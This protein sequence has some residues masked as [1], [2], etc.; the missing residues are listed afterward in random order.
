MGLGYGYG[1]GA[2]RWASSAAAL[3][4]REEEDVEES[5]VVASG[6]RDMN[7]SKLGAHAVERIEVERGERRS[8]AIA[9]GG[10]EHGK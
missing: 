1:Y 8:L 2:R 6:S 7:V 4:V 10:N 9:E 3:A 5:V